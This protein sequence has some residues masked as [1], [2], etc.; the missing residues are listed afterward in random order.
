MLL[1]REFSN[2]KLLR[3]RQISL[4]LEAITFGRSSTCTYS[5]FEASPNLSRLQATLKRKGDHWELHNGNPKGLQSANGIFHKGRRLESPLE[6]VPGM[7]VELF[8]HGNDLAQLEYSQTLEQDT[9]TGEND[10]AVAIAALRQDVSAL[11]RRLDEQ[12]QH[13]EK[14][15]S[16]PLESLQSEFNTRMNGLGIQIL[17]LS[18]AIAASSDRDL[19]QSTQLETHEKL[20]RKVGLGMAAAL[21]SLGGWNLTSGNKDAVTQSINILFALAG[22]TGGTYLLQK[23]AKKQD[24]S[25]P[26]P[27]T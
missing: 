9:Y 15:L 7:I 14:F 25:T 1:L 17:H 6:I 20:I 19:Q 13:F 26:H 10:L 18:D 16:S 27:L 21:L 11:A 2:G 12:D 3:E 22:G 4:D 5:F 8:H 24:S 23:E